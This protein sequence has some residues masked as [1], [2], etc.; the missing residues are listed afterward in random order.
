MVA[1][2]EDVLGDVLAKRL[3]HFITNICETVGSRLGT[4]EAEEI[5]GRKIFAEYIRYCDS[6]LAEE[7][8][9]HPAAFLDSIRAILVLYLIGVLLYL[10]FPLATTFFAVLG[11]LIFA[12]EILYL[13]E[14]VD[15]FF[16]RRTGVN[17]Y[18]KILPRSTTKRIVLVSG[19]HDSA[20]EFPLFEM[21]GGQATRLITMTIGLIIL[22]SILGIVRA[23]TLFQFPQFLTLLNWLVIIP[24]ISVAPILLLGIRL[25][26]GKVVKGANDNLS[27]VAVTLGVGEWLIRNPLQHTEVWLVSF[28]CEENMRGSKRF[29]RAHKEELQHAYLLNFDCVGVGELNIIASESMFRTKMTSDLCIKVA[30]AAKSAG[31]SIPIIALPF[32]G[33]D[34]SNFIKANLQ[35]T[36]LVGLSGKFPAHW[37]TLEDTPDKIDS[38][39]LLDAVKVAVAFLQL[40]D[41][42]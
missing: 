20:Y 13:K 9:C 30:E 22:T 40:V 24:I 17:I 26:S 41:E 6:T 14:V 38:K 16:P 3:N 12:A 4:S 21:L 2:T 29:A 5:T 34:A 10:V 25:R 42:P 27:G 39:V 33:T 31:L 7:F 35:A 32:G 8:T 11:L 28:S 1:S 19:H 15:P 36:S 23:L 18:G 37:H